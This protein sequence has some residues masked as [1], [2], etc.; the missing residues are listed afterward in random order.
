MDK[1]VTVTERKISDVSDTNKTKSG[2]GNDQPQIPKSWKYN[3]TY[4]ALGFT[5]NVIED[6][7]RPICV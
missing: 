1:Y 2:D 3:G 7:D 5:V 6:E 4:L